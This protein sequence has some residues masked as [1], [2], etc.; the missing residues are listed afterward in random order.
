MQRRAVRK[1]MHDLRVLGVPVGNTDPIRRDGISAV[2]HLTPLHQNVGI[3]RSLPARLILLQLG[4]AESGFPILD[5]VLAV[6][7]GN[8]SIEFRH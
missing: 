6:G 8:Q 2:D 5:D 4:F 3:D 1:T 7:S